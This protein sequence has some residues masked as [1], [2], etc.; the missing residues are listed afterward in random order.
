VH[1]VETTLPGVLLIEPQ[2]WRDDRG[3]FLESFNDRTFSDRGIPREFVQDNHSRSKKGVLR[4][5]HYQIQN[6]QGKL[7]RVTRGEVYDVAVDVRRN[8]PSFGKWTAVRLDGESLKMFWVPPGFAH[9]YLVLSDV[10]DFLYKTTDYYAPQHERTILF[11]DP[12]LAIDWPVIEGGYV[13]S[14]KDRKGTRL[15]DAEVYA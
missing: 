11:D 4:G 5:L 9:G 10:A 7:V 3:F 8:S 15:R 2:V 6:P 12:D 14:E 1:V 13:L